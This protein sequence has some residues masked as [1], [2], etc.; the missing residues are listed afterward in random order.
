[1]S[2]EPNQPPPGTPEVEDDD[3]DALLGRWLGQIRDAE[4]RAERDT[5]AIRLR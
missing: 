1:M 5:A 4:R 3:P 2:N